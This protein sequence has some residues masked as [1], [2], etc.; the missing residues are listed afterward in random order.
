M[1]RKY[2]D[3]SPSQNILMY[4]QNFTIHKQ[5]NN[6]CT[7]LLTDTELDFDILKKAVQTAY[8]RNDCLRIRLVKE[9]KKVRQ[10]FAEYEEPDIGYLDFRGKTMEEMEKKL[11]KIAGMRITYFKRPLSKVWSVPGYLDIQIS[12]FSLDFA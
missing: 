1:E 11:Y 3:L 7:S 4:A 5:V 9:G 8:E 12:L 6:I 10:Y 2:Y